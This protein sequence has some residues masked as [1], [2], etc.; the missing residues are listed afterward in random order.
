MYLL[1][2]VYRVRREYLLFQGHQKLLLSRHCLVYQIY[3]VF[4]GHLEFREYQEYQVCLLHQVDQEH[5]ASQNDQV[6]Q[7][8][9]EYLA[10]R[11]AAGTVGAK[12]KP[13]TTT[14]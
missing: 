14:A 9:Q 10:K 6:N 1:Y 11:T 7:E 5:Q 8:Y 2:Q 3:Q 12:R 13:P 4:Q